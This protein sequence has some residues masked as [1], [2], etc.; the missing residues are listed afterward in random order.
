MILEWQANAKKNKILL[1]K[2]ARINKICYTLKRIM[3][4]N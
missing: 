1:Y 3:T 2:E 4:I